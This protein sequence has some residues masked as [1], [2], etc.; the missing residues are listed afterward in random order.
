M[1]SK[2]F[3]ITQVFT[4][5]LWFFPCLYS[6]Y[7]FIKEVIFHF[8]QTVFL[9]FSDDF[10]PFI[11]P[12]IGKVVVKP[13]IKLCWDLFASIRVE[14]LC[15]FWSSHSASFI[16]LLDFLGAQLSGWIAFRPSGG[17]KLSW[18][19]F[20]SLVIE[21][22]LHGG[23]LIVVVFI[24]FL[25]IILEFYVIKNEYSGNFYARSLNFSLSNFQSPLCE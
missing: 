10:T 11:N 18:K 16:A 8:A 13:H 20:F 4:V 2:V 22:T 9:S 3:C 6:L 7:F 1:D 25:C 19:S 17:I 15:I 14:A 24:E 12:M 21:V 23:F 5:E